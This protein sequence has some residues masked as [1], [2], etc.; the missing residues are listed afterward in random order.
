VER[1]AARAG[2]EVHSLEEGTG[3]LDE[4]LGVVRLSQPPSVLA[5]QPFTSSLCAATRDSIV[6][7]EREKGGPAVWASWPNGNP[8]FSQVTALHWANSSD[9]ALLISGCDDGSVRVWRPGE[10]RGEAAGL[11]TG[12]HLLPE[13]VPQALAGAR[14][15]VGLVL[16]WD[17][18]ASLLAAAGDT[19]VLRLWDC[20]AE[21]RVA[22][23]P[24]GSESFVTC[25]DLGWEGSKS[26]VA[27]SFGDGSVR[28]F[29]TRAAG[30]QARAMVHREHRQF[31]LACRLQA[32]GRL[33]TGCTDGV[34]KVW[35][36]R[37]QA[38]L[39]TIPT[40]Q[41]AISLDIHQA[42]PVFAAWTVGQQISVHELGEG[43]QLNTVR[44]HEGILGQRLGPVNC[45]KFHPSLLQ[46]AAASTDS[47][48]SMYGYRRH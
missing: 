28:L 40:G 43:R 21:T 13:L 17:Q 12:W 32:Q 10:E 39:A 31:L 7:L 4:Q 25:L 5:Y 18:R 3:R 1:A 6:Q 16:A 27:A 44:Y 47:H 46:L 23:L 19:R 34:V 9:R 33:V 29:D 22:D 42:A 2:A 38:S 35:D 37:R 48:V 11:V 15:S 30:G 8:R 45:L 14:V 20:Q 36:V 26:V 24:T 41:P